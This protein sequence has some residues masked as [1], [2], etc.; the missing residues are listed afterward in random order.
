ML[1]PEQSRELHRLEG[2]TVQLV[3]TIPDLAT[4]RTVLEKLVHSQLQLEDGSELQEGKLRILYE[5]LLRVKFE[6]IDAAARSRQRGPLALEERIS[7][8]RDETALYM[9]QHPRIEDVLAN[10]DPEVRLRLLV[11][12]LRRLRYLQK[13]ATSKEL[14]IGHEHRAREYERLIEGLQNEEEKREREMKAEESL[15]R[16]LTPSIFE[17]F[18]RN[19]EPAVRISS[20]Q[21]RCARVQQHIKDHGEGQLARKLLE[22]YRSLAEAARSSEEAR[23]RQENRQRESTRRELEKE[24]RASDPGRRELGAGRGRGRRP[25]EDQVTLSQTSDAKISG[26]KRP[27]RRRRAPNKDP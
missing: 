1:L 8:I 14:G 5:A 11:C 24:S 27:A 23:A 12:K 13:Y 19:P 7:R 26:S 21:Y 17:V 15:N 10:P 9:N 2:S 3:S 6:C 22:M 25:D 18:I 16:I 20:L 4:R